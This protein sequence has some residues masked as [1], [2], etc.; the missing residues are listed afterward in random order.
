MFRFRNY[1]YLLRNHI[2]IIELNISNFGSGSVYRSF[3][4][5]KN[6]QNILSFYFEVTK[7]IVKNLI[8]TKLLRLKN[9]MKRNSLI[10]G[11]N[12]RILESWNR[13]IRDPS[14]SE[15]LFQAK[16]TYWF[17]ESRILGLLKVCLRRGV[18]PGVE[19]TRL[20]AEERGIRVRAV[21][22]TSSGDAAASMFSAELGLRVAW[23]TQ[24]KKNGLFGLHSAEVDNFSNPEITRPKISFF[25]RSEAY[26]YCN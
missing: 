2:Q 9:V 26:G 17:Q 12:G 6:L 22:V 16:T 20:W 1:L 23:G 7:N 4:G 11:E 14:G 21:T 19:L 15:S 3:S 13:I 24:L 18:R 5:L 8:L 10:L 25:T